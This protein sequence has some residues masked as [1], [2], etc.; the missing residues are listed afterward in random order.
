MSK[1]DCPDCDWGTCIGCPY[2]ESDAEQDVEC[3]EYDAAEAEEYDPLGY[4]D[5]AD[6]EDEE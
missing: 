3:P 5:Q 4:T 6:Y 1:R 2:A